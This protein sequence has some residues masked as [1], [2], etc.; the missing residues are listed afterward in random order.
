MLVRD[1]DGYVLMIAQRDEEDSPRSLTDAQPQA[2]LDRWE[3]RPDGR[4]TAAGRTR[5]SCRSSLRTARRQ[6]LKLSDPRRCRGRIA[7]LVAA[8]LSS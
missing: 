5:M 2:L 4:R 7:R 3:L 6:V 1:P 8:A